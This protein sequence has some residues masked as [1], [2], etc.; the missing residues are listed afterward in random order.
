VDDRARRE[1]GWTPA[2]PAPQ[3]IPRTVAWFVDNE[4]PGS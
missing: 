3:A 4:K 1:L 2:T